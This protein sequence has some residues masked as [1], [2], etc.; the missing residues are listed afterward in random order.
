[1]GLPALLVEIEGEL[2]QIDYASLSA[3]P[4]HER[5][6]LKVKMVLSKAA[7]RM[8]VEVVGSEGS[9]ARLRAPDHLQR[10]Q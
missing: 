8:W 2:Y 4:A 10:V 1:M 7:G 3:I 6:N 9:T 5:E